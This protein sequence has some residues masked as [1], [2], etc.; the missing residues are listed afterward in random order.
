MTIIKI[1]NQKKAE[2][3]SEKR[4]THMLRI[5]KGTKKKKN[6]IERSPT[7]EAKHYDPTDENDRI[8]NLYCQVKV[9]GA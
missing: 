6:Q 5:M 3:L 8:S 2:P 9:L 1:V 7:V 4:K